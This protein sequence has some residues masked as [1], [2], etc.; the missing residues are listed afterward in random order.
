[1]ASNDPRAYFYYKPFITKSHVSPK[2]FQTSHHQTH[3]IAIQPRHSD[4]VISPRHQ[5]TESVLMNILGL[6]NNSRF[7]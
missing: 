7:Y 2:P 4:V 6:I 3:A 5:I 1:M